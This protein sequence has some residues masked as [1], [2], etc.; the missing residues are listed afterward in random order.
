MVKRLQQRVGTV[1]AWALRKVEDRLVDERYRRQGLDTNGPDNSSDGSELLGYV[2]T[3]WRVNRT[4]FPAN[5]LGPDDVLLDYGCG[6]GRVTLWAASG[7]RSD[8]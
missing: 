7:S 2:A 3:D 5:T 6:K 4:L 8:V 1:G